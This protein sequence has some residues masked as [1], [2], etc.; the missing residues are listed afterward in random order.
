LIPSFNVTTIELPVSIAPQSSLAVQIRFDPRGQRGRFEDRLELVFREHS[1]GIFMITRPLRAV[2]GNSDLTTLA[3]VAPYRRRRLAR[4][5]GPK[6]EIIRGAEK[7]PVSTKYKRELPSAA[8][9]VVLEQLLTH[10]VIDHQIE[11]FRSQFM[12]GDLTITSY[13]DYWTNLVHAEHFQAK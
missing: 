7:L 5:R 1:G 13:Q 2:V 3:P 11:A 8:I 10:G 9:P 12:P 4:G 6:L